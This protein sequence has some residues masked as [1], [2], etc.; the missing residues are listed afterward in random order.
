M[1]QNGAPVIAAAGLKGGVGKTTTAVALASL[2]GRNGAARSLLVDADPQSSAL[3]WSVQAGEALACDVISLPVR[4]LA[5]RIPS[6]S[7]GVPVVIDTPP[8][9]PAITR[10]AILAANVVLLPMAPSLLEVD[11]LAPVIEL[12]AEVEPAEG[13]TPRP[14]AVVLTRVRA[15]TRSAREVR[16]A[17]A[18]LDVPVLDSEVPLRESIVLAFGGPAPEAAYAPV[19]AELLDFANFTHPTTTKGN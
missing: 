13:E 15:S 12:L 2:L 4:D 3:T 10:A 11:R 6:L 17:L 1:T 5:R 19:L 7:H 18:E 8:G 14:Y 16:D 9:D